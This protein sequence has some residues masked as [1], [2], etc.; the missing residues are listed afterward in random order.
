MGRGEMRGATKLHKVEKTSTVST[1]G[2]GEGA[3]LVMIMG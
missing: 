1:K 3:G 2:C